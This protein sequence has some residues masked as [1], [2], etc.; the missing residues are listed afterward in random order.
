MC[1]K[2][3]QHLKHVCFLLGVVVYLFV[4]DHFLKAHW[5][6][7]LR[8]LTESIFGNGGIHRSLAL[9]HVTAQTGQNKQ[10]FNNKIFKKTMR[11]PKNISIS[12]SDIPNSNSINIL[13][14]YAIFDYIGAFLR[15]GFA[16]VGNITPV[17]K[18]IIWPLLSRLQSK[19]PHRNSP[20]PSEPCLERTPTHAGSLPG[21]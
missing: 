1:L 6:K 10:K 12:F 8:S 3:I 18:T 5:D 20:E 11:S 21:T 16:H 19:T 7:T 13:M 2:M 17:I 15:N 14:P 9:H 4:F